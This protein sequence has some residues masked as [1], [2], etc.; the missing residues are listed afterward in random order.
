MDVGRFEEVPDHHLG[1]GG[2]Q[3]RRPVV[4]ATDQ[5][6]DQEPAVEE[7]AGDGP[8]DLPELTGGPHAE[9]RFVTGHVTSLPVA[10]QPNVS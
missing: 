5:G 10:E 6:A 8:P 7:Q 2:P 4:V 1:P 9:D 3:R